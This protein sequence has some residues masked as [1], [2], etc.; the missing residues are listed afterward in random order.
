MRTTT[1]ILRIFANCLRE[2]IKT[3]VSAYHWMRKLIS[4]FQYGMLH[5]WFY[6]GNGN[7]RIRFF[8]STFQ[9]WLIDLNDIIFKHRNKPF[10]VSYKYK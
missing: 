1:E 6:D 2:F 7:A 4:C 9:V 3:S 5:F 8:L 10:F